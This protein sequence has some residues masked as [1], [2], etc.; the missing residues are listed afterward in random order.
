MS[1]IKVGDMV[2][3]RSGKYR[4]KTGKVTKIAPRTAAAWVE[5]VRIV[6]RHQKKSATKPQGG[7]VE[8]HLSVPLSIISKTEKKSEKKAEKKT[9]KS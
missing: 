9:T 7:I 8:K 1:T 3:V 4:G 2:F 5:G 6:K